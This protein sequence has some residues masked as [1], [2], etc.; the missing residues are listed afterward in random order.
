MFSLT[1]SCYIL[2][3]NGPPSP[4]LPSKAMYTL[5]SNYP[6]VYPS[7]S[8]TPPITHDL[9]TDLSPTSIP[10]IQLLFIYLSIFY[11][12]SIA[13]HL[14]LVFIYQPSIKHIYQSSITYLPSTN[15]FYLHITYLAIPTYFSLIYYLFIY[16]SLSH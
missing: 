15:H 12:L 3:H 8:Y 14:H 4:V 1:V 2:L 16:L 6:P 13:W 7:H 11:N 9:S 5:S 10:S